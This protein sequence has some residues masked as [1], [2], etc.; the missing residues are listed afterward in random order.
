MI[1]AE[2]AREMARTGSHT[3]ENELHILKTIEETIKRACL[4][5][6][7]YIEVHSEDLSEFS[8]EEIDSL[9]MH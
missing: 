8:M 6:D 1:T 7:F 3:K 9:Y 5:R 2:Q 4:Y